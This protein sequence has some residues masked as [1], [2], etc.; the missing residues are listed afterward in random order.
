MTSISE[1]EDIAFSN[2]VYTEVDHGQAP[3]TGPASALYENISPEAQYENVQEDNDKYQNI[4]EPS[5]PTVNYQN[6]DRTGKNFTTE[7][8]RTKLEQNVY[9]NVESEGPHEHYENYDFGENGIY[10]NI[11]FQRKTDPL[12]AS[13]SDVYSQLKTLKEAVHR[14]NDILEKDLKKEN[15][16][17]KDTN[18][19]YDTVEAKY[20]NTAQLEDIKTKG[21]VSSL[22]DIFTFTPANKKGKDISKTPEST[23]KDVPSASV[24]A[25]QGATPTSLP[26]IPPPT[27]IPPTSLPP[28]CLPP[29]STI[30][31][32]W[33]LSRTEQPTS[34]K[35]K[36]TNGLFTSTERQIVAKFLEN[37]KT[38]L[39]TV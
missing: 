14:V 36:R 28:V 8:Q 7:K 21:K 26:S 1:E 38:E 23:T 18:Q 3:A 29:S 5:Q 2:L 9:E 31:R 6:V 22:K 10:Q 11:L 24:P 20:E 12:P 25:G 27:G 4:A 13:N 37:V 19:E 34:N 35:D 17:S 16:S 33:A 32:E 30:F 15:S 39:S